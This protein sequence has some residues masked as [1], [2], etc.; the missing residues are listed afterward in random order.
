MPRATLISGKGGEKH[1]PA[2]GTQRSPTLE[3][4]L[5]GTLKGKL[6]DPHVATKHA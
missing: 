3:P 2:H 4:A 5:T 6:D 1:W